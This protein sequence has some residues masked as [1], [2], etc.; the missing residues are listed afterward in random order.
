MAKS[1]ESFK[2]KNPVNHS[3]RLPQSLILKKPSQRRPSAAVP[4]TPHQISGS[5]LLLMVEGGLSMETG[6][7]LSQRRFKRGWLEGRTVAFS[8]NPFHFRAVV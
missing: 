6:V 8:Y 5:L 4:T 3:L 7:L 1:K 2:N